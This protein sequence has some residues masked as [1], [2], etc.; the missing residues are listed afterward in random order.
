MAQTP[1][2]GETFTFGVGL[3]DQSDVKLLVANPTIA[4]GDFT[5]SING[6]AFA[7]LDNL[8]TVTPAG[9]TRVEV[10][11]SA[12]E[13]NTA[14]T[15]GNIFVRWIDQAGAEWCDGFAEVRYSA[16]WLDTVVSTLLSAVNAVCGCVSNA[17]LS[18][19]SVKKVLQ[20]SDDPLFLYRGDTW[21]QTITGLGDLTGYDDI[22]FGIKD[23]KDDTDTQATVLISADNGLE[24]IDG[25]TAT[26]PGNGSIAVVGAPKAGTILVTLEAEEA[27]KLTASKKY[28]WD[29]QKDI[30][31]TITTPK[32]GAVLVSADIVRTTA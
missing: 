7:N 3:F 26:V 25:A 10:T 6:G 4:A 27:A 30:G 19:P 21:T 12:A 11:L 16:Y 23:D 22:W 5:R 8:P 2:V 17:I 28:H 18:F 32:C 14:A 31:G 20:Q 9:G 29:A 24:I 13:G 15:G 1:V